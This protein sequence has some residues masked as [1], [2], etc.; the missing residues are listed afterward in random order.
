MTCQWKI[1]WGE[2]TRT[3]IIRFRAGLPTIERHPN[4]N[5]VPS[6]GVEPRLLVFQTRVLPSHPQGIKWRTGRRI[7]RPSFQRPPGS[8][9]IPDHSGVPSI[10]WRI[11]RDSNS[12]ALSRAGLAN[13]YDA[14]TSP[15]IRK[16]CP[17]VGR[18]PETLGLSQAL[19]CA[20][21]NWQDA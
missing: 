16:I 14:P 2:R 10:N 3:S 1:G 12:L 5:L 17:R 13:Q 18:Y 20:S 8:N 7:E 19:A 15:T 21:R 9:R 11:M 6:R 4:R